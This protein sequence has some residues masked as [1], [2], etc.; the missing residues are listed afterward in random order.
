MKRKLKKGIVLVLMCVFMIP[1]LTT[2]SVFAEGTKSDEKKSAYLFAYFTSSSADGEQI[3]FALSK[4][5]F[6]YKPLN[7]NR[8]VIKQNLGTGSV[9]DPYILEGKDGY[10]YLIGT[11]LRVSTAGQPWGRNT[12]IVTWKSKDLIDWTD[13]TIIPIINQ[14]ESTSE[15]SQNRVWAPEAVYDEEKGEYMIFWSMQGGSEIYPN[16]LK[17][18]YSYTKD[19]KTL[20][21]EPKILYAPVLVD[22]EAANTNIDSID[23]NIVEKDGVFHLFY[24][25]GA[26]E[27]AGTKLATSNNLTGPYTLVSKGLVSPP[28]VEGADVFKLINED[29][30]D[31]WAMI[32]DYYTK[33]K[34]GMSTSNDLIN[35]TTIKD[36]KVD[37]DF[38]PRH[39]YV[40]P[41]TETQYDGLVD[42]WGIEEDPVLPEITPQEEPI[43]NYDFEQYNG[44]IVNDTSNKKN[45]GKIFG[46]SNYVND[47]EKG[48]VLY[49]DGKNGSYLE[50][51]QGLVD[52]MDTFSISLDVK[53][54]MKSGN[55]FVF[56]AG[57]DANK[58]TF[59]KINKDSVRNS[60]TKSA[61]TGEEAVSASIG[62]CVGKWM[63]IKIVMTEDTMAIYKD[64]VLL[65]RKED[66]SVSMSD[67]GI[68]LKSY[69]GKSFYSG[70]SYF[71]G[72]FDNV[73]IYNRELSEIEIADEFG[74]K[75][76]VI[77]KVSAE[78]YKFINTI[79][80]NE[81]NKVSIY[82]KSGTD[83]TNVPLKFE[84]K[85]S[86][87]TS[88]PVSGSK[89]DLTTPKEY[90]IENETWIVEAIESNNPVL[91]GLYADPDI[92]VFNGRYYIYPT[93]DGFNGWSGTYFKVFSSDDLINW[94]DHGKIL[95][96]A[97][98]DVPWATG[99]AWAPCIAEN[100]GKY[101]FY[102]CANQ[103]IGVAVADS[104]E[105][106]FTNISVDK[107][108]ISWNDIK[109]GVSIGQ[110][111]DPSVFTDDDGQSYMYFGNGNGSPAVVKLNDDMVSFDKN[112]MENIKFNGNA[113]FREAITVT[114]RGEKYHFTWSCDD[115]R[116]ENYHVKY[117]IS[118]S[119]MGEVTVI[120]N[121]LEKQPE[122]GILGTGHHSMTQIPNKDEYYIAY[123]RFSTTPPDG[124]SG[125]SRGY[126]REVC[127]E[128]VEFD[129]NGLMKKIIPTLEGLPGPVFIEEEP[130]IVSKISNLKGIASDSTVRLTWDEPIN[131]NGLVEYILYKDGKELT[132][133]P[134]GSTEYL[135]NLL[136]NNTIY[137]FK[138][139]TKYSNE[140]ISKP[141]S[142]NIRTKKIDN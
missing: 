4:D 11:D 64:G 80:N 108:M 37:F 3:R 31:E 58:Y 117:G 10:Y 23:A 63:N 25:H 62:D 68:N 38:S 71:K 30:N 56:T 85:N 33:G 78:G 24:K 55:Y 139:V 141:V 52:G 90:I 86:I 102:Y 132:R 109:S 28:S 97:S 106:P 129:E 116:S 128:K 120:G 18:W 124:V 125:D 93:T 39:G 82:V 66:I 95:D 22:G 2:L 27:D 34:Y 138:V 140:E 118:D 92:A 49:L 112:T 51:P 47:I 32:Y 77:K 115:T 135:A 83:L 84:F 29:D 8:P 36:N 53:S 104:P 21:E 107:P 14:Y 89:V 126:N 9:R 44:N 72:Y 114:K 123:H 119:P 79:I 20:T 67:L 61:W 69:L 46:S 94:T 131:K 133:V 54:E 81:N 98:D 60:I 48:S 5:G 76:P 19:F 111:I 88:N 65:G 13:E 127:I 121:I 103:Q 130:I 100:N 12:S 59:L 73:K 15:E 142:M 41:I 110:I 42:K 137:G 75:L 57:L 74:I 40:I 70:D 43:V 91:D 122:L 99:S 16:Q 17:I 50:F 101:Y 45:N 134:I 1:Q 26:G 136:K 105:G 113:D 7:E 96:V 87:T 6:K 35:F